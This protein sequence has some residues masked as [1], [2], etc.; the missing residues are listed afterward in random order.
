MQILIGPETQAQCCSV[1]TIIG[2]HGTP[3]ERC[4]AVTMYSV[5]CIWY[6]VPHTVPFSALLFVCGFTVWFTFYFLLS[7]TT[8][9]MGEIYVDVEFVSLSTSPHLA[10]SKVTLL[11]TGMVLHGIQHLFPPV[12]LSVNTTMWLFEWRSTL[13]AVKV[14]SS[15]GDYWLKND[16][17]GC[18]HHFCNP[19]SSC[20]HLIL[21]KSSFHPFS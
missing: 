1:C 12:W 8:E 14:T 17:W 13:H 4:R 3:T 18:L 7:V 21:H 20:R 11:F 6:L 5:F 15:R 16:R 9:H 2:T 19:S 10:L